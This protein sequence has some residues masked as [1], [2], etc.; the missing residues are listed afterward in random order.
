MMSLPFKPVRQGVLLALL[1]GCALSAAAAPAPAPDKDPRA[2]LPKPLPAWWDAIPTPEIKDGVPFGE[3]RGQIEQWLTGL[4]KQQEIKGWSWLGPFDS[5]DGNGMQTVYP[6]ESDYLEKGFDPKREYAGVPGKVTWTWPEAGMPPNNAPNITMY[7][8]TRLEWPKDETVTLGYMS[9]DGSIFWINRKEAH[10]RSEYGEDYPTVALR[11]GTNEFFVKVVNGGG[12]W[13]LR[14]SVLT[15]SP[16]RCRL[17]ALATLMARVPGKPDDHIGTL[18]ETIHICNQL[19]ERELFRHYALEGAR[20][21]SRQAKRRN[22]FLREVLVALER[23]GF[24]EMAPALL[25]SLAPNELE[26][27]TWLR[28][29]R[30]YQLAGNFDK[31]LEAY[32]S[33]FDPVSHLAA[34]RLQAGREMTELYATLGDHAGAAQVLAALLKA[35]PAKQDDEAIKAA[36][37]AADAAR[38]FMAVVALDDDHERVAEQA[39]RLVASDKEREALRLIQAGLLNAGAKC[40]ASPS[41]PQLFVGAADAYRAGVQKHR[42]AYTKYLEGLPAQ[43][44]AEWEQTRRD[45][46]LWSALAESLDPRAQRRHPD[47]L[48]QEIVRLGLNH[49]E[50]ILTR[51]EPREQQDR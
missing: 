3:A 10:R 22:E 43:R 50:E 18:N 17:K 48:F 33:V 27:E 15:I 7:A 14:I 38:D 49:A 16:P 21:L 32:R 5:R 40:V 39:D 12:P 34:S 29:A 41:D 28:L 8:F 26:E 46:V 36:R 37:L 13:D 51:A 4:L 24:S 1:S 11:K 19:N 9:D 45:D 30:A 25:E 6:P 31:A 44:L 23:Y 35:F 42:A 47:R 2:A 20:L